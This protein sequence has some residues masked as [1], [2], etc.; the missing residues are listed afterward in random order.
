MLVGVSV[1][2]VRRRLDVRGPG[3]QA[4]HDLVVTGLDH[5]LQLA[6]VRDLEREIRHE[7][8]DLITLERAVDA[9]PIELILSIFFLA[10]PATSGK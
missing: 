2:L 6:Q 5:K 9:L 8:V 10:V 1:L 7:F 3:V 4:L